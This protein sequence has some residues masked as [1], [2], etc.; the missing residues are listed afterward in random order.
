V[1]PFVLLLLLA[2]AIASAASVVSAAIQPVDVRNGPHLFVDDYLIVESSGVRK[3]TQHPTRLPEPVLGWQ[4]HTTQPYV[5]VLRDPQTRKFRMWYNAHGGKDATIAYAESDDG[6]KWTT[7]KL[8]IMGPDN[9]LFL[10]GR[11]QE[12]GSYGV[13]VIDDRE[14]EKDPQ[15]RYKLMW[16]SGLEPVAGA[17]VAWSADGLRWT[18]YEKNPVLPYYETTDSARAHIGVGDIV[19]IF[20]DPIRQRYASL[21]KLHAVKSDGWSAGPRAGSAF[22]R[23]VGMSVSDDFLNWREPWRVFTPEQRDAGQLEFYSSGGTIARGPLLITFIRMLHD[24]YS[25]EEGGE[26]TGIGYTTLATSRD[27]E[28]WHRHDDIFLDRNPTPGTWDR[29]MTWVGSTLPVGDELYLYYGGYKRGHKVEPSKERQLG[30]AK[31]P[32]DRFVARQ[33]SGGKPGLI[34]TILLRVGEGAGGNLVLNADASRGRIRAQLRH[35]TG[36]I[37][38]GFSFADCETIAEDGLAVPVKW[39]KDFRQLKDEVR[40]ELEFSDAKIFGFDVR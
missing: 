10:I 30:L 14:R 4:Q 5:T 6:V 21:L 25:P 34:R 26:K 17:S 22:R 31:M 1:N 8:D 24:D 36:G 19:D 39:K 9:R 15:R 7:P 23:L 12:H 28:H 3:V 40:L 35:S 33:A 27:G 29:A 11:S 32:M 37:V 38:P 16:W 18:K 13:S 2:G 20:Y